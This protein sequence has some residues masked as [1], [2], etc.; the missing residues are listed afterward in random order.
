MPVLADFVLMIS[1]VEEIKDAL[2]M[3]VIMSSDYE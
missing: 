2:W 3:E 1:L